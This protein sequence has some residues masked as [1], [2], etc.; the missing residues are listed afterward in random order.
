MTPAVQTRTRAPKLDAVSAAAVE[1]AA[2]ALVDVAEPGQVGAHVRV[3]A[4]GERLVTHIFEATIPGYAGWYWLAI[5][6]RAPRAKQPTV[7]ET[8]LVPGDEAL[9]APEWE[10]WSDRLRPDDVGADDV[11]PYKEYDPRLEQGFEQTKDDET[12]AVAVRELGLGRKRVLS[13]EGREEAATR[14]IDGEFGPRELSKRKRKGTVQ[15][16]CSSCGFLSLLN[17]SLRQEFGICTNEWSPADGRVVSLRYGCGAHS[18]TDAD[19]GGSGTELPPTVVDDTQVDY[20]DRFEEKS[21]I[22]EALLKK[23]LE[24]AEKAKKGSAE[25]GAADA[26]SADTVPEDTNQ[27]EQ[28]PTAESA[29]DL[30]SKAGQAMSQ[31]AETTQESATGESR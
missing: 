31:A 23:E 26:G 30:G 4:S 12:E 14:W 25:A 17:G 10:P 8:A 21:I 24:K 11:L 3:E 5:L 6:A 13:R 2:T 22:D 29:A 20:V 19:T 7:C 27:P 18:E 28:E 9:L 15:A 1:L 16:H